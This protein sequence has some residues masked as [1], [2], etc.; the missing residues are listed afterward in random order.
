MNGDVDVHFLFEVGKETVTE[1]II[2]PLGV[3]ICKMS[4]AVKAT[5]GL[6]YPVDVNEKLFPIQLFLSP[7]ADFG[8]HGGCL[9]FVPQTAV[10]Y[11]ELFVHGRG[12]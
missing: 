8:A 7:A 2:E 9:L 5:N 4:E 6:M 12:V 1:T 10:A 3:F 11:D